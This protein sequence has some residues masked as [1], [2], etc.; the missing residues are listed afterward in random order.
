MELLGNSIKPPT[1]EEKMKHIACFKAK[2]TH[3]FPKHVHNSILYDVILGLEANLALYFPEMPSKQKLK[4]LGY[5]LNTS[6]GT[7]RY[8]GKDGWK[9]F[10]KY[11]ANV[12]VGMLAIK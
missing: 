10:A 3:L 11:R 12:V 6:N 1:K 7:Y 5:S 2:K 8:E 4:D 9:R